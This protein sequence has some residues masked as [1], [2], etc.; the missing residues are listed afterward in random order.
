RPLVGW[1]P[2]L[3]RVDGDEAWD[4]DDTLSYPIHHEGAVVA[5]IQ[6]DAPIYGR[7]PSGDRRALLG[8]LGRM[9]A[10][11][12][13]TILEREREAERARQ[14]EASRAITASAAEVHSPCDIL[15]AAAHELRT[16][17]GADTIWAV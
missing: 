13:L 17:Y 2:A 11:S 6:L 10:H 1:R 12:M 16:A 15:S 5:A 3:E 8:R 4:P 7:V 14:A 9:A